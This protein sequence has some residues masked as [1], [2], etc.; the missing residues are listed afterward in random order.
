M[1]ARVL[2][3]SSLTAAFTAMLVATFTAFPAQAELY[4]WVD[5]EGKT[6]YSDTPPP[7]DIKDVKSKKFGDNVSGPSDNLPFELREAAKKNPVTLYA[8]K[9]GEPCDGARSLLNSRGIP[10]S[11]RN[12]ES[13]PAA[14]AA[15][16]KLIGAL[17][18]PVMVVGED[19]SRGFSESTWS[20]A[21]T[22]AGYPRNFTPL[23]KPTD[24]PPSVKAPKPEETVTPPA[25]PAAKKETNKKK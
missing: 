25:P 6:I 20:G 7:S 9:C 1:K 23:A 3:L 10:F 18:V 11:E 22:Q 13:D 12:P 16:K 17:E 14:A 4:K 5:K 2:L 24:S 21:L 19:V 8:N 15:L